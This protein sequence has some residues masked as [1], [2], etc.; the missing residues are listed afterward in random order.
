[1]GDEHL[2]T[3]SAT[4]SDE[5][6][7]SSVE[8]L[9]P[10]LSE[11]EGILEH[12]CDVPFHDNS[13][14]LY[15]LK[16]QFEDF[17]ES[18]EE[19]SSTDDD[20]FSFDKIDYVE[21]SPLDSEH[22]NSEVMEI[23]IPEVGGIDDDIMLTIKD[24]ILCENLLNVN[25][26]FAKIEA[27]NDNPILFYDP[28]ISST[29]LNLTLSGESDLFLEVDAFLAVED[30]PT[31]SQFPKSYLDPEGDI[32]LLEAFL[33]DDHSFD[34]KTNRVTDSRVSTNAPLPSSSPSHS[35]DLQQI[36]ASLKDKLDIRMNHFE[37]SL[38]DM[39]AFVTPTA[40]IKAVKEVCVTCGSNHSYNH[41]PLT[42]GGNVFPI[43]H[44]NIQ[45]FQ[46]VAVR[47]FV[48]GNRHSN[49]SSQMRPPG[50]NQQNNQNKQ[51]RYQGNNFNS[52]HNQNRQ[53]NQGVVYQ[54]PRQQASTYQAPVSQNS[55]SNNKFKV[56][57]KA[58]DANM[59]NFSLPSNTIPNPRNKAK[60]IT[61]R[62]GIS[63]D[64]PS[65]PPPVVEKE[66]EATKD[67]KLPSTK[68]IQPPSVQVYEKDKEPVDEPFVAKKLAISYAS[69]VF[70]DFD[71]PFYEL[72]VFKE[73]PNSMR[74]LPFSFEN[75]EKVFKPGI[76]TSE[77]VHYCFR[78]E[79]SH[80]GY[81]VF[82][83]SMIFI[84]L[85]KIFHV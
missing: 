45:Q 74:L 22:V 33:N 35:F 16:D 50:F 32:L 69:L 38:N 20:S 58:N 3:I 85:M 34:F 68:N 29:P 66:I 24:D 28:I 54:N 53:N 23:V 17:S 5:F 41:F 10:I 30:E 15:I 70:E 73:V 51:K 1:M 83:I 37:K 25:H 76:Y 26:L 81:P 14:P 56:Y 75:E 2:D 21:A 52:N 48:Q 49:L 47:N 84:I 18:N 60:A 31:S 4:E 65:I 13:P 39:K 46:T 11:S 6:I 8:D 78:P 67:T 61:T 80:P 44:D 43:F 82:K 40:P 57:M 64:G 12:M 19:F 63:Y 79:L 27:S 36:A 7:K 42:R 72:L 77:K 71:P 59:N 62:S 55:V 9:I